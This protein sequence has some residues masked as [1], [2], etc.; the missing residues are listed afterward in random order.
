MPRFRPD[1]SFYP[2]PKLAME[3]PP[4]RLAYVALLAGA[5]TGRRDAIGVV[6]TD[7]DS[8]AFGRLV[9]LS[10]FPQGD[11][12]LHHFGW[13]A[14]SSHLCP[15]AANAHVDRRYL[16]VPGTHSSRI[17]ILDTMPDPREPELVKVIEGDEVM[18]R[19]GYAAPHTVHCG[20]DGIYLNALGA[21]DGGGPGGIFMLDHESFEVKGPWERER[22]PQYL[23]YDFFWHL[24][25]DTMITS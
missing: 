14:C 23:A 24:G 20:P 9:G 2:S 25:H 17:H 13:N 12:E 1:P 21:P 18:R 5:E 7:P 8:R 15:W 11:N 22:G 16:I 6:D 4:E 19:T 3:A 10:E